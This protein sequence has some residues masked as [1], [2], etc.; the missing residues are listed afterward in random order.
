[1]MADGIKASYRQNAID[2]VTASDK[3]KPLAGADWFL[4]QALAK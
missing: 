1:M 2:I 3:L 4:E